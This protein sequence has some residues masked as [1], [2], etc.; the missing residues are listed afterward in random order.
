MKKY[1]AIPHLILNIIQKS[2]QKCCKVYLYENYR[3]PNRPM[4]QY[5]KII[6]YVENC[7]PKSLKIIMFKIDIITLL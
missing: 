6:T 3:M 7:D 1:T 4:N 2:S 5:S